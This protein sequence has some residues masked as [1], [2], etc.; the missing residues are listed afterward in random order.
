MKK[1]LFGILAFTI[2]SCNNSEPI[3]YTL[4]SGTITNANSKTITITDSDVAIRT[5]KVSD[6]GTFSDTIFNAN[7]YYTF[8]NGKETS[9]M[10]L[11][12]G[13]NI[14]LNM[15]AKEFDETIVYSGIGSD[16]NNFLAQ[17][18]II[19]NKTEPFPV[20]YSLDETAYLTKMNQQKETLEGLLAGLDT[21]FIKQEKVNIKYDYIIHVM[22][23]ELAH[24]YFTKKEDFKVSESFP[25]VF[26]DFK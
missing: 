14:Q 15:D 25:K 2:I 9:A 3:N 13:Y 12:D 8:G 23:Y 16:I 19:K 5:I 18:K 17:K 11:K 10:Y 20:I 22:R 1:L 24:R 21:D 26:K 6:T 4:F 7:G